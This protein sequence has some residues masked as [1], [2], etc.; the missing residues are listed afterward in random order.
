MFASLTNF[1]H[2]LEARNH[3]QRTLVV[4]R[5]IAFA[6]REFPRT[7]G[8][9]FYSSCR[10]F[11]FAASDPFVAGIESNTKTLEIGFATSQTG[12]RII[13]MDMR[14]ESATEL[15]GWV[16]VIQI[17]RLINSIMTDDPAAFFKKKLPVKKMNIERIQLNASGSATL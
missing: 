13:T 9:S 6:H 1:A 8:I 5:I 14:T 7:Q 11:V 4:A 10:N 16:I 17:I 3:Q 2:R 12:G 15:P